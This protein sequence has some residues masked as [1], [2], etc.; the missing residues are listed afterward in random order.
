VSEQWDEPE[1]QEVEEDDDTGGAGLAGG[2]GPAATI[3]GTD[4][5]ADEHG[6]ALDAPEG[7][8]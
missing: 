1:E 7:G 5:E 2:G 3:Y 6:K 4:D 8:D